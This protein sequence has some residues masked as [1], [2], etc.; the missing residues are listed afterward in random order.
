MANEL[1]Y[2]HNLKDNVLYMFDEETKT[3]HTFHNNIWNAWKEGG[4]TSNATKGFMFLS[5]LGDRVQIIE[6][7]EHLEL[8]KVYCS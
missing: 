2:F 6:D 7:M 1:K 4:Y 3:F 5:M 8:L